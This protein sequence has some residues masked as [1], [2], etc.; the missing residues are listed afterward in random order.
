MAGELEVRIGGVDVTARVSG[1]PAVDFAINRRGQAR[2]QFTDRGGTDRPAI[3]ADCL[4]YLDSALVFGGLVQT[5]SGRELQP[6]PASPY[7]AGSVISV[8]VTDYGCLGR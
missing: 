4:I 7:A 6:L 8:A 2:I 3:F 1:H 5:A